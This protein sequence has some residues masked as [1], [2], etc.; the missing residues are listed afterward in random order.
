MKDVDLSILEDAKKIPSK[1]PRSARSEISK[2]TLPIK[3]KRDSTSSSSDVAKLLKAPYYD[4]RILLQATAF[5]I[6][7]AP[8]QGINPKSLFSELGDKE[9]EINKVFSDIL[10]ENPVAI[11]I[12]FEKGWDNLEG[13]GDEESD[14]SNDGSSSDR[15]IIGEKEKNKERVEAGSIDSSEGMITNKNDI[16]QS[17]DV[18]LPAIDG[19]V[20]GFGDDN[21]ENNNN[22][23]NFDMDMLD[24]G[25]DDLDINRNIESDTRTDAQDTEAGAMS[26]GERNSIEGVVQSIREKLKTGEVSTFEDL[27]PTGRKQAARYFSALLSANSRGYLKLEQEKPFTTISITQL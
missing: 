22:N 19:D 14:S 4:N 11:S 1:P 17:N 9:I 24:N 15:S 20:L 2:V 23:D 27:R 10:D 25:L 12:D 16:D 5:A 21:I 18:E 3:R 8:L 13:M 6:Q 26:E 7:Q